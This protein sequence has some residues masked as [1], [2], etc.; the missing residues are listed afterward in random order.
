MTILWVPQDRAN[1]DGVSD[2]MLGSKLYSKFYFVLGLYPVV[3][4]GILCSVLGGC[5]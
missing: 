3:F 1:A 4:G 5:S 2:E